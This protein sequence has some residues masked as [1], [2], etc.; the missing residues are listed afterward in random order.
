MKGRYDKTI[1]CQWLLNHV[2]FPTLHSKFAL[3]NTIGANKVLKLNKF[4]SD[5]HDNIP[6]TSG[7]WI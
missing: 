1:K 4:F 6:A 5:K 7:C 3:K 2:L